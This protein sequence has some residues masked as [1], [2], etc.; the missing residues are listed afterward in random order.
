MLAA[1]TRQPAVGAEPDMD[2]SVKHTATASY[3]KHGMQAEICKKK[4]K[5]S[6]RAEPKGGASASTVGAAPRAQAAPSA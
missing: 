4:K 6:N 2:K 5:S 3:V 1:V